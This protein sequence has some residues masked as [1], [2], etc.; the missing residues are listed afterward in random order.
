MFR[1][2]SSSGLLAACIS[3]SIPT[4]DPNSANSPGP[5]QGYRMQINVVGSSICSSKSA[6]IPRAAISESLKPKRTRPSCHQL[7][8]PRHFLPNS[9]HLETTTNTT[10]SQKEAAASLIHPYKT[11]TKLP[12]ILLNPGTSDLWRA[13][14]QSHRSAAG[15]GLAPASQRRHDFCS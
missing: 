3:T 8:F 13:H 1:A 10:P 6:K 7:P 5:L 12:L 9:R 11:E 2:A 15:Y 4:V 14:R